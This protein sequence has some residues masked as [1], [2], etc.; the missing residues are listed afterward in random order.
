MPILLILKKATKEEIG[1]MQRELEGYIKVAVDISRG[2]LAGGGR[3]HADCES[4]LLQEESRQDEVW[5]ADWYPGTK[6]VK[7][8][9]MINIAP[10]RNNR[11]M[12]IQNPEIRTKVE[13][14]IR[15]LLEVK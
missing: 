4:L 10:R 5:G 11:S 6:E 13:A 12:E 8:E 9:A 3:L 15:N 1:E 7:F 14:V 2:I